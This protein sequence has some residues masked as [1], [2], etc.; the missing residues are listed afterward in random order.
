MFSK[1]GSIVDIAFIIIALLGLAIFI[2]VIGYVY[3]QITTAIRGTPIGNNTASAQA[4]NQVD[5]G[6][7]RMDNIFL[8]IFVG[9]TVAL[10]VTSYKIDSSPALM[11]IYIILLALL[12]IIGITAQYVFEKFTE[13]P[14][15][16]PTA[17]LDIMMS[18]IMG[19]LTV[20]SIVLGVISMVLIFAK[21]A[22]SAY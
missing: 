9:L 6:I 1:R 19:N 20:I 7:G 13:I 16:Q 10:F 15:F 18:K 17:V 22:R 4:L 14:T 8:I 3:P 21:P 5:T 12:V 11:P 2:V